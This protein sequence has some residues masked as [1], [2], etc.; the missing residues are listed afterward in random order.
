MEV[1][2]SAK[3]PKH[4]HRVRV[5]PFPLASPRVCII[6]CFTQVR[7]PVVRECGSLLRY[8]LV[9]GLV[10]GRGRGGEGT[11]FRGGGFHIAARDRRGRFLV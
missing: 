6:P 8:Y 3:N 7:V 2:R 1:E 10:S 11:R 4:Q 5:P 9:L